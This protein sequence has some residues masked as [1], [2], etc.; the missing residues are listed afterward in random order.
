MRNEMNDE[1]ELE[2]ALDKQ[3]AVGYRDACFELDREIKSMRVCGNCAH[4]RNLHPGE[5]L[6]RCFKDSATIESTLPDHVCEKWEI[7][8]LRVR[9][10]SKKFGPYVYDRQI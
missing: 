6:Y 8:I 10:W 5:S 7:R 2:E 3:H 4:Y 9:I 1:S